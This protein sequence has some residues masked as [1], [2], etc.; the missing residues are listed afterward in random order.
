MLLEDMTMQQMPL[1]PAVCH[2]CGELFDMSYDL[3]KRSMEDF[4][5]RAISKK[6]KKRT[7]LCWECRY[8]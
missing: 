3:K 7:N 4:L 1:M 8:S 2:Q 6:S 5:E